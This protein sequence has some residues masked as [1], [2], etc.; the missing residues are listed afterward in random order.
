MVGV[1][2]AVQVFASRADNV[3][4]AVYHKQPRARR[5]SGRLINGDGDVAV[6]AGDA[7]LF[8]SD[9]SGRQHLRHGGHQWF[10]HGAGRRRVIADGGDQLGREEIQ[11]GYQFGIYSVYE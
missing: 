1:A 9:L 10:E 2:N 5:G 11:R 3:A 4:A 8:N 6:R 7:A